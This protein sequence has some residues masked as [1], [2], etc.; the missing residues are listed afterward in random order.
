[1]DIR[2][3]KAFIAVF[4]E[5][6]ITSAAQ[7]LC[8][9]QPTL[10]VTIKQLEEALGTTLFNRQ[11]RGVEVSEEARSLYPQACSL[12]SESEALRLRFRTSQARLPLS[13]GIENDLAPDHVR[14]FL[15]FVRQAVPQLYLTLFEGCAG[16][17]RLGVEDERCEDELF[18][19]I[20]D[21]P[22]VLISRRGTELGST[23]SVYPWVICPDHPT[24]QRLAPLYGN[25]S[26]T[27]VASS[28]SLNQSVSLVAAGAGVAI[29][30]SSLV[31]NR[32]D[33][34][35]QPI[36]SPLPSRRVGLCY[37]SSALNNTALRLT[38]TALRDAPKTSWD[39]TTVRD[40]P[41][42]VVF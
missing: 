1:M 30:P 16:D 22:F 20:W 38:Y 39:T 40:V 36:K 23:P 9:S 11:S 25:S 6:N 4:E 24:H 2:H 34:I 41:L 14:T 15:S 19:P 28:G 8:I 26:A 32:Q 42:D 18:L 29:V 10:S 12:V 37:G 5:R 35:T 17:A 21:D 33:V 27:A 3:L 13:L 31:S 7:R